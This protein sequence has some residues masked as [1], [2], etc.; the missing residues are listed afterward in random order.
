MRDGFFFSK[1]RRERKYLRL[2]SQI[3]SAP[4]ISIREV[5]RTLSDLLFRL[6]RFDFSFLEV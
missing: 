1:R 5:Q 3:K 2:I 4:L 6:A